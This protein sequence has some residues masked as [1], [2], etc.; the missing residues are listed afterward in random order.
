MEVIEIIKDAFEFPSKDMKILLVYIVLSLLA[1]AFSL[2]GAL[3]YGL[4]FYK[5]E[6]FL[7]GGLAL[8]IAMVIAWIMYGYSISVIKSGIELDDT[9]PEFSWWD[10]FITGFDNFIVT[11]VYFIIIPAVRV[12]FF[13]ILVYNDLTDVGLLLRNQIMQFFFVHKGILAFDF[14]IFGIFKI[15]LSELKMHFNSYFVRMSS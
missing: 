3:M 1:G 9:V 15:I 4:G 14:L 11:I 12:Y 6:L 10:N 7:W 5:S 2:G 8:I 13:V